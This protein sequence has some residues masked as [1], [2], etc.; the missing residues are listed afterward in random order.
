MLHTYTPTFYRLDYMMGGPT[1]SAIPDMGVD[2]AQAG[3]DKTLADI[4]KA[5]KNPKHHY[6]MLSAFNT[7]T[8]EIREVT[9]REGINLVVMGTQGASGVMEVLNWHP[10]HTRIEKV[11]YTYIGHPYRL[12]FPGNKV[13]VVSIGFRYTISAK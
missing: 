13:C 3:L 7:L 12:C 9:D 11:Q 1:F 8:D 4:K 6:R 5:H 10:Y 2:L